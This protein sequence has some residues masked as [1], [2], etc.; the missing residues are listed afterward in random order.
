MTTTRY[1]DDFRVGDIWQSNPTPITAEEIM[2]F[3]RKYDPQ[4]M[5]TDAEGAGDN[6]FGGLIASGWFIAAISMRV[7]V[8][9][10]GY[11]KT[12]VVGLGIDELRWQQPVKAGD[13]LTVFRE[14]VELRR[15]AS[16]PGHG[17]IKTRVTVR[18]QLGATVM[19]LLTAGRVPARPATDAQGSAS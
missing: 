12:P 13:V 5:H 1:F 4:P 17:I 8:Q 16:N 11:G 18:N 15:S 7:F 6:P 9:A 19:S 3:G 14:V 10:G 2:D